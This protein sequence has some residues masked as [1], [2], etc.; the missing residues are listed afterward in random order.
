MSFHKHVG[1]FL[2]I[3]LKNKVIYF[4]KL[5][6]AS[7]FMFFMFSSPIINSLIII[8][9]YATCLCFFCFFLFNCDSKMPIITD[10]A[11]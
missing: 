10:A 9:A 1:Y 8:T 7:V 2:Y 5:A 6:Y 3:I 4:T 11:S